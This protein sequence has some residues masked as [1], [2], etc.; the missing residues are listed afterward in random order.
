MIK[1]VDAAG[2]E[3]RATLAGH[4]RNVER[5]A[6]SPDGLRLASSTSAHAGSAEVKLWDLAEAREVLGLTSQVVAPSS[7]NVT[8]SSS[9]SLSLSF[10]PD[11]RRLSSITA[12]G[13][14]DAEIRTWDATPLPDTPTGSP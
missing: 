3:E 12:S 10:S 1:L 8:A 7:T 13:R 6:F 5:L 4:S 14:R 2:G 9:T 11:G